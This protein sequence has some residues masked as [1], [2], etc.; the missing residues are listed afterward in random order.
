MLLLF[1]FIFFSSS[2]SCSSFP[3]SSSFFLI[4]I[5]HHLIFRIANIEIRKSFILISL[6]FA[7]V[8]NK[9]PKT[10]WITTFLSMTFYCVT[11][12]LSVQHLIL[13]TLKSNNLLIPKTFYQKYLVASK[14]L[15]FFMY[16]LK[17]FYYKM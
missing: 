12:F 6:L 2:F 9:Y 4:C 3:F 7:Q 17:C 5:L 8:N 11:T 1:I 13:T 14:I 15:K 10:S 16:K